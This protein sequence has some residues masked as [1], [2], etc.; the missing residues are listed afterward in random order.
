[1]VYTKNEN[2]YDVEKLGPDT[3]NFELMEDNNTILS[4]FKNGEILFGDDLPN[5]EIEA[6]KDNGLE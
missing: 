6:M 3:I 4:A 2:Y 5:D 1:M